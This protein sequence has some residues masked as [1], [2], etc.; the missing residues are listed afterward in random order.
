MDPYEL[1]ARAGDGKYNHPE[2]IMVRK[3]GEEYSFYDR[4]FQLNAESRQRLL[5]Y[6]DALKE[7]Q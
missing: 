4:F 5:G 2:M 7:M 1:L 6:M 3:G